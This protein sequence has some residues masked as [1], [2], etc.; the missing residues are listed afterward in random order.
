MCN[1]QEAYT[2]SPDLQS[3]SKLTQNSQLLDRQLGRLS[4]LFVSHDVGRVVGFVERRESRCVKGVD[5]P[6]AAFGCC[7]PKPAG[8]APSAV[9]LGPEEVTAASGGKL[10]EKMSSVRV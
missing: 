1:V 7:K 6:V 5:C 9:V 3:K 2:S 8:L 10:R 4:I